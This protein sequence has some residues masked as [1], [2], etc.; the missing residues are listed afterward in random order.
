MSARHVQPYTCMAV[1][2]QIEV[3]LV[4]AH[5]CL[6]HWERKE[7]R[8]VVWVTWLPAELPHVAVCGVLHGKRFRV[9]VP[10]CV[11]RAGHP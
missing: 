9:R 1:Q 5:V 6:T 2:W 11:E 10:L 3:H 4:G 8:S 7:G